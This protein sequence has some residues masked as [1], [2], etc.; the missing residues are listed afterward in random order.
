VVER[1][2]VI[3]IVLVLLLELV[4]QVVV[5]QVLQLLVLVDQH[6]VLLIQVLVL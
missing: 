5:E 2:E 6:L 3:I 4:V 1:A